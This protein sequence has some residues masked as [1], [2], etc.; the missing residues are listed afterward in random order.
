MSMKKK[1][2]L[3]T[4]G[5]VLSLSALFAGDQGE[6]H[7]KLVNLKQE[8]GLDI[9]QEQ[10]DDQDRYC[11]L[12][13]VHHGDTDYTEEKRLQGWIDIPLN[14]TGKVQMAEL[15]A[16]YAD[17][18]IA[19][20]YS[21]NL[22]RAVESA[23]IIAKGHDSEIVVLPELRGEA[24]G[25]LEGLKKS[26]Y[27]KDPHFKQYKELSAEDEIFF[28]VGEG[29]ES[30]AD[31]ARR[32]IPAIKRICEQHPGQNIIIVTHGGVLKFINFL[33]GNYTVDE[34]DD[35]PHG[36]VLRIDGDGS[37]LQIVP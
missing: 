12:Y 17:L 5:S 32:A 34:I 35:V 14:S 1:F 30:K 20:I 23:E 10:P 4:T 22:S 16:Q 9:F 36:D 3:L 2:W 25:N 29:G 19:T 11:H 24:H 6:S 28:S 8:L 15:A 33:L 31:V 18:P 7:Q 21:S 26:E 37:H 27:E 13:I